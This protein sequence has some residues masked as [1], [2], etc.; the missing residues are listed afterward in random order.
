MPCLFVVFKLVHTSIFQCRPFENSKR[1]WVLTT[2]DG[3]QER[4]IMNSF[5]CV[6]QLRTCSCLNVH[7]Y[8]SSPT[9]RVNQHIQLPFTT[10]YISQLPRKNV[11]FFKETYLRIH[12]ILPTRR[13]R[14]SSAGIMI[15]LRA[16][17]L[18]FDPR[19]GKRFLSSPQRPDLLCGPSSFLSNGYREPHPRG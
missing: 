13:S 3:I 10:V 19:Q 17:Q 2:T 5:T 11:G 1:S 6:I 15:R 12:Y 14:D 8:M 9:V 18:G 16:G 7:T 4:I